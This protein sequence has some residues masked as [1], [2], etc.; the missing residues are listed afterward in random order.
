MKLEFN[1]EQE[2][3]F[4]L[5]D[6]IKTRKGKIVGFFLVVMD[7]KGEKK[8]YNYQIEYPYKKENEKGEEEEIKLLACLSSE[9]IRTNE[10]DIKVAFAP[11]LKE[12]LDIAIKQGEAELEGVKVNIEATTERKNEIVKEIER[13]KKLKE[14]N[15]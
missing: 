15:K 11:K 4:F 10:E 13:L 3:H 8:E 12:R 6:A 5:K 1:L 9:D 2:V 14:E 7:D